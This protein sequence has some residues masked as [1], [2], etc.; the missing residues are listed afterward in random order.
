VRIGELSRATGVSARSLRYYER[1]GPLVS[2][3]QPNGEEALRTNRHRSTA[4][5]E[6]V[7]GI[8]FVA[9]VEAAAAIQPGDLSS[10]VRAPARWC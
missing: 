7:L 2:H 4:A 1:Q 6:E 9:T 10:R 8:A 3:R 5:D